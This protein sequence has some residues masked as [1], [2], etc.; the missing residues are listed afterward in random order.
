MDTPNLINAIRIAKESEMIAADLYTSA[1]K[2]IV[3]LGKVIF[4]Q[5]SEFE[6]FHY[7][8][9]TALEK[10]LR[11]K[12]EFIQ[13]DG[14]VMI[15]PPVIIIRLADVPEHKSMLQ[16]IS[17]A[18]GFEQ[19]AEKIYADLAAQ[20]THPQGHKLFTRL[21]SDERHHYD[22]L[23]DAFWSLNQTGKWEWSHP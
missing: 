11:E 19:Q 14:K 17:E 13:Y 10:S 9:L 12:G 15:L 16:I 3:T 21:A 22:I 20:V 5:L 18:M 6:I 23:K 8:L 1:A 4:E 2:L 7:D